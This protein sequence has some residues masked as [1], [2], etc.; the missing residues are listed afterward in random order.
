MK[1]LTILNPHAGSYSV[2]EQNK[3]CRALSGLE[4]KVLIT[5]NLNI[6]EQA[7]LNQR[8]Y[9]TGLLGIG[10]GD[11]TFSRTLTAVKQAWG[12]IPEYIAA[13]A[14]GTMN[15][16]A[17]PLDASDSIMDKIKLHTKWGDTRAVQLA[18]Y[19]QKTAAAGEQ[20]HFENLTPLN[21][22]GRIGFNLGFG[23][24]PKLVWSY[25]GRSREQYTW[26]EQELQGCLPSEYEMILDQVVAE[27]AAR[28]SGVF[29]AL[30]TALRTTMGMFNHSSP[31]YQFFNQPLEAKLYLDG[32]KMEF[33]TPLTGI[34]LA[35][36]E[37]QNM[38]LFRGTP[39]P[40]AR[41]IP[42]MM[43][44]L[45]TSASVGD[46]IN[47]LPSIIR[48]QPLR[49]T[50]YLHTAELKIESELVMIGQMDGEFVVGKEFTIKPDVPLKF[51]SLR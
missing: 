18:K 16:V 11:G 46:I 10:G 27:K 50:Q 3:I 12:F 40:G 20:P 9:N 17:V 4:G 26:A 25:Y 49:N 24:V 5:P 23:L 45:V 30:K 32:Q 29:Q 39:S 42:G 31:I 51:V 38:G 21:M 19:I 44:V 13:Y 36:Y 47:D 33:P 28:K 1:H 35:S 48:G 22:N 7:L 15:N 41:A 43:E 34:Y 37:Q 14:M 6:L 8:D 2:F